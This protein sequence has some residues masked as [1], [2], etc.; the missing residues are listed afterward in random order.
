MSFN[1]NILD[2]TTLLA[3]CGGDR[4]LLQKMID[5]FRATFPNHLS[6]LREAAQQKD[7]FS[8]RRIAH[9]LRGLTSNYSTS[10]AAQAAALEEM[11]ADQHIDPIMDRCETMIQLTR[12]LGDLLSVLTLEDL[13]RASR[14]Q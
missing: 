10:V 11:E 9:Q 4:V 14:I 1:Q 7:E 3:A 13:Q 8:F 2:P 12:D 5:S 6:A